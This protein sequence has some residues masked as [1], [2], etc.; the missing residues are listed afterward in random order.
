MC[1]SSSVTISV[2]DLL[3]VATASPM[4]WRSYYFMTYCL[5]LKKEGII[6]VIK[7]FLGKL[8]F[9]VESLLHVKKPDFLWTT[10]STSGFS[11]PIH[12]FPSTEIID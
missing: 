10:E 6:Y 2:L 1:T 4:F 7:G 12:T 5:L 3:I 8:I 11:R 9:V